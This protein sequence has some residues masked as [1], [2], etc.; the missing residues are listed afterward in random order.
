MLGDSICCLLT[1]TEVHT[2]YTTVIIYRNFMKS[3]T[4]NYTYIF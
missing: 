2:N 3:T 1:L 4:R